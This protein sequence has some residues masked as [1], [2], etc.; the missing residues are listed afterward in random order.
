[1]R[2]IKTLH[3]DDGV[4]TMRADSHWYL[5]VTDTCP[6]CGEGEGEVTKV[7]KWTPKPKNPEDRWE[8]HQH[9]CTSCYTGGL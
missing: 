2:M 5:K 1:M 7:R 9:C 4:F 6:S 8:H 3:Y